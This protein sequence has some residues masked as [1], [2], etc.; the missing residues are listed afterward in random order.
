MEVMPMGDAMLIYLAGSVAG[1]LIGL[2][3]S[4]VLSDE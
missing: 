1:L 3:L 4:E 2:V